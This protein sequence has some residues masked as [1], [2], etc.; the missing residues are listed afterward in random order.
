MAYLFIYLSI[1]SHNFAMWAGLFGQFCGSEWSQLEHSLGCIQLVF[2][3][4]QKVKEGFI[5]LPGA[6][7][8]FTWSLHLASL[9]FCKAL[10]DP[11]KSYITLAFSERVFYEDKI[12]G[13]ST[14]QARACVTRTNI[15]LICYSKSHDQTQRQYGWRQHEGHEYPRYGL[16]GATKRNFLFT[17]ST[18]QKEREL[19]WKVL[20]FQSCRHSNKG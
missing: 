15:P 11:S 7:C 18:F 12:Q 2:E 13:A 19:S 20:T 6:A 8:S 17:V 16:M 5:H 9:S 4:G 3:L 10:Q 14:Y 1:I